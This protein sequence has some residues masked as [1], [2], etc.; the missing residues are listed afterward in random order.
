M[1]NTKTNPH[2]L[3]ASRALRDYLKHE[4]KQSNP[5]D[6]GQNTLCFCLGFMAQTGL[7]VADMRLA[8]EQLQA[9]ITV[10]ENR[11]RPD[12]I[13]RLKE[14]WQRLTLFHSKR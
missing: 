3:Q 11:N 6:A 10:E 12:W 8:F 1:K 14:Y 9:E 4:L 5:I 2:A 13:A 7:T